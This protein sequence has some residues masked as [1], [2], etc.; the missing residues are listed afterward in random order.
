LIRFPLLERLFGCRGRFLVAAVARAIGELFLPLAV[1]AACMRR[2]RV[3]YIRHYHDI[4]PAYVLLAV[5]RRSF[6]VE[7]NAT[8]HEESHGLA[9]APG[10]VARLAGALEGAALRRAS[11]LIVVSGVLRERLI[12]RGFDSGRIAVAQNGVDCSA[13]E[14]PAVSGQ[15]SGVVYVGHFKSWHRVELL[16]DAYAGMADEIDDRLLLVGCGCPDT[17]REHARA[18]GIYDRVEFAGVLDRPAVREAMRTAR[19]L[20]LPNTADYGSPL[21]LFEY[22]ASGRPAVLPDLP[23]I[24]E[25]VVD[26]K[27]ALLFTPGDVASLSLKM[28][29]LALDAAGGNEIGQRA[30]EM[31]C[32][33]YTWGDAAEKILDAV[34]ERFDIRAAKPDQATEGPC[35]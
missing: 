35:R 17:L 5:M 2:D 29:E 27:H 10:W 9:S 23:N 3:P 24:R 4:A 12:A 28:K 22:L 6:V 26:G 33:N 13:Y 21:K 32:S 31:V 34:S 20:V 30:R 25:V 11:V 1:T 19:V 8:L 7:V 16:L 14:A 18:L 15:T